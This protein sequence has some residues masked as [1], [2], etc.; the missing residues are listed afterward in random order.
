MA[1]TF[2][3]Q[4]PIKY[5]EIWEKSPRLPQSIQTKLEPLNAED[6]LKAVV[7]HYLT[8]ED[9]GNLCRAMSVLGFSPIDPLNGIHRDGKLVVFEGNRRLIAAE[10]LLNPD[11]IKDVKYLVR[12]DDDT[13]PLQAYELI[14]QYRADMSEELLDTLRELPIVEFN[15]GFYTLESATNEL[16]ASSGGFEDEGLVCP[17]CGRSEFAEGETECGDCGHI[18]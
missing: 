9:V 7:E 10:L 15:S 5:F 12:D 13:E 14:K 16:I 8:V 18:F 6:K 17:E 1:L 2:L 11:L 4:E 3:K